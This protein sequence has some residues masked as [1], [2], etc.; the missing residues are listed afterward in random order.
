MEH[1]YMTTFQSEHASVPCAVTYVRVLRG[2]CVRA[3][4]RLRCARLSAL[5]ASC[6]LGALRACACVL[7]R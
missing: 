1:M 6:A 5:S 2:C 4:A 7:A 3:R